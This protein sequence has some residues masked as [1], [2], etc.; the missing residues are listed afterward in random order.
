MHFLK[1]IMLRLG[2]H[3]RGLL[4]LGQATSACPSRAT[5]LKCETLVAPATVAQV[6]YVEE[7]GRLLKHDRVSK[8]RT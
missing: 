7:T 4:V 8:G 2:G 6:E 1:L 5:G 3:I